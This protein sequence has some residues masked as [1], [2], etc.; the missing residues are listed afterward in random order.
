MVINVR[1]G[2]IYINV[3]NLKILVSQL[4]LFELILALALKLLPVGIDSLVFNY[5]FIQLSQNPDYM[6][7]DY[8]MH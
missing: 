3:V 5:Q 1:K 4:E 8:A 7:D 6:K 2:G